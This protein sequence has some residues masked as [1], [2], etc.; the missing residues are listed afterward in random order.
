MATVDFFLKIDGVDGESTDDKHKGEI[1][2]VSCSF[3]GDNKGTFDSGS[4]G[5]GGG[6][7]ALH[8][9]SFTKLV[10]KSSPKLFKA[11][12]AGDHY[13]KATLVWRKAGKEQ[14][15]FMTVVFTH[16]FVSGYRSIGKPD[17]GT[18]PVDEVTLSFGKIECKYKEQKPDGSLGGEIIG[19]WDVTANKAI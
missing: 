2:L 10:D 3:G 8:D 19:G 6:R 11:C 5:A 1:E 7:V 14:Q 12:C 18:L 9:F 4:G 16:V 17:A 15:E 13:D